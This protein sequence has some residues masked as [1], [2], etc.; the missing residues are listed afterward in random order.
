MT[1]NDN[2]T[3]PSALA[4]PAELTALVKEIIAEW[5]FDP[6]L[7]NE[8][9]FQYMLSY[10]YKD[11]REYDRKKVED[12]LHRIWYHGIDERR[13]C[14]ATYDRR[15]G[16]KVVTKPVFEKDSEYNTSINIVE[17]ATDTF[18]MQSRHYNDQNCDNKEKTAT[19]KKRNN[20]WVLTSLFFTFSA[21]ITGMYFL[22]TYGNKEALH[23]GS[24][25]GVG[26]MS[27]IMISIAKKWK[28]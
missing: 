16:K 22:V 13:I 15:H 26:V 7:Y 23:Y 2:N 24:I 9:Y 4:L 10:Y 3:S 14:F 1:T 11:D 19:N 25:G 12:W 28:S 6:K 5:G 20:I 8:Y 27:G 21:W 17:S 18:F